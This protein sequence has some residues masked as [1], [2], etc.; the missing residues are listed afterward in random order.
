[1]FMSVSSPMRTM[2]S[3][4]AFVSRLST[5]VSC[6]GSAGFCAK[7]RG[8]HTK[9]SARAQSGSR[10]A[11]ACRNA[12]RVRRGCKLLSVVTVV[13]ISYVVGAEGAV[14]PTP[15][16]ELQVPPREEQGHGREHDEDYQKIRQARRALLDADGELRRRG[17]VP[18]LPLRFEPHRVLAFGEGG[19]IDRLLA[20][21][22][23]PGLAVLHAVVVLHR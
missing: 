18:V 11:H 4:P 8:A 23:A 7:T 3:V 13:T 19:Q 22:L 15:A 21:A 14:G 17:L 2:E 10:R 6:A 9:R 16:V 5:V 12:R 1:M 20:L